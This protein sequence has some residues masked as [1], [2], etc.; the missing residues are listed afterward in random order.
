MA[1]HSEIAAL[2]KIVSEERKKYQEDKEKAKKSNFRNSL[3]IKGFLA[4]SAGCAVYLGLR[5]LNNGEELYQNISNTAS[6][7]FSAF[8]FSVWSLYS[9]FVLSYIDYKSEKPAAKEL[10]EKIQKA[11]LIAAENRLQKVIEDYN[12]SRGYTMP[13]K[14]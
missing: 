12:F 10:D 14:S 2:E 13:I 3:M 6:M 7:D 4:V 11:Q 5:A 1:I 8:L 9:Y